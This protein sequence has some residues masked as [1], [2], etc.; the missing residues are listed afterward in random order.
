MKLSECGTFENSCFLAPNEI[1][2][3]IAHVGNPAFGG[4]GAGIYRVKLGGRFACKEF[5]ST[6][7]FPGEGWSNRFPLMKMA[8]WN[9]RSI[10]FER[11]KYCQT[12]GSNRVMA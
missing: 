5:D 9:C 6:C 8:T 10:T 12:L 7:G 3:I 1:D 11:F 4:R 2:F